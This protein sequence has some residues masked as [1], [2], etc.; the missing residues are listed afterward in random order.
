VLAAMTTLGIRGVSV[1][2]PLKAEIAGLVD[3]LDA[4]AAATQSVNT[5]CLDDAVLTGTST[6]GAGLFASIH[7]TTGLSPE[8][9]RVLVVGAG[10]A[11][12]SI[13]AFAA[14]HGAI[15]VG[16]VARS[17]Q[18]AG[19]AALLGGAVPRL[20][21]LARQLVRRG[22]VVIER[23]LKL[24]NDNADQQKAGSRKIGNAVSE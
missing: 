19:S 5:I 2:M 12:R 3:I 22:V 1:T 16:V 10:G 9:L 11:A 21:L 17:A 15:E 8:G 24:A 18:A 4:S 6:D 13:I 7:R 14:V 20:P 23:V